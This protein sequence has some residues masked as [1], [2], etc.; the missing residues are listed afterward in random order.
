MKPS[1]FRTIAIHCSSCRHL[2]YKYHKGGTGC[3]VKCLPHRIVEP[4]L[5]Q[6][7]RLV[8]HALQLPTTLIHRVA[9]LPKLLFHLANR[10]GPFPDPPQLTRE[11]R[12]QRS[13]EL[14]GAIGS[15]LV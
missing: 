6:A 10:T 3:L 11:V 8:L 13:G 4:A 12:T 2:L 1:G 5:D 9:Q 14:W 7:Y 15:G